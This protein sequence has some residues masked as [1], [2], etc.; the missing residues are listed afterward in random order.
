MVL[1]GMVLYCIQQHIV[2]KFIIIQY[3]HYFVVICFVHGW[4]HVQLMTT[5]FQYREVANLLDAVKQLMTHF[6]RY[7]SIPKIAAIKRRVDVIQTTLK[8]HVHASFREIGQVLW[9]VCFSVDFL[10]QC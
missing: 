1:Y 6:E 4:C 3:S 5:E 10:H 8:R 9:L 7:T 2:C